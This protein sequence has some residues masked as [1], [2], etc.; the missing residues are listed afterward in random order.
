MARSVATIKAN[1][2][3]LIAADPVLGPLL[4]T[5]SLTAIFGEMAY[6]IAQDE[7]LSEQAMDDYITQIRTYAQQ[8]PAAS[9]NWIA[10]Q[11]FLY[12][13][14]PSLNPNTNALN[15]V[16]GAV[17]YPTVDPQFNIVSRCAA[18]VD[19][20]NIVQI[21][22][23]QSDPPAQI[24]GTAFTQ[25]QDYFNAKGTAG[26]NY[27][28]TSRAADLI[29]IY[30]TVYYKSGYAGV[31]QTN[32]ENALRAYLAN[33]A[34]YSVGSQEP[35][36]YD[37]LIKVSEII[38]TIKNTEGVDDF[39][40]DKLLCRASTTPFANA[41]VVYDISTSPGT[42]NRSYILASGYGI[43]ETDSA[44]TWAI[45]IKYLSA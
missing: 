19:G 36:N 6:I 38:D 10:A 24:T 27:N 2:M 35:I 1:I 26:I 44:N 29:A 22:V 40:L 42:N 45:Q 11:A 17:A 43:E 9:L 3:A 23:A 33:I 20:N 8:S 18:L 7:N 34:I 31:A 4:T 13:Y 15:I 12:Q 16:N 32:V 37:G 41:T 25:L 14:D 39:E 28:V 21:K 30:G 5:T